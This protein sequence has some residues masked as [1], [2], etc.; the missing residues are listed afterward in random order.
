MTSYSEGTTN[1]PPQPPAPEWYFKLIEVRTYDMTDGWLDGDLELKFRV[2]QTG[3]EERGG[4]DVTR[5]YMTNS[6]DPSSCVWV[7]HDAGWW[8]GIFG[9]NWNESNNWTAINRLRKLSERQT[10]YDNGYPILNDNAT[11]TILEDDIVSDDFL[12]SKGF[13][14]ENTNSASWS[15]HSVDG[16]VYV[17]VGKVY[18]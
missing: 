7:Y 2:L 6:T 15:F 10:I 16:Y 14:I 13:S 11:L 3:I 12:G 4:A 1:P 5:E 8:S 18:Q 9:Q 17:N